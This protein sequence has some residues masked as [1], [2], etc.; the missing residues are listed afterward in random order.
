[1]GRVVS[2]RSGKKGGFE[3]AEAVIDG[4]GSMQRALAKA[5]KTVPIVPR[6]GVP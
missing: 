1:L 5:V 3:K 6:C 2:P 4:K